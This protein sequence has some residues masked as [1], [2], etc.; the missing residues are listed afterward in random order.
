MSDAVGPDGG[1][2]TLTVF[3]TRVLGLV[4]AAAVVSATLAWLAASA[5]YDSEP[6]VAADVN[7]ELISVPIR[8]GTLAD[9]VEFAGEF[10]PKLEVP[11]PTPAPPEGSISVLTEVAVAPGAVVSEGT[12]IVSISGRPIIVL[13]GSITP[14]RDLKPGDSGADVIQ[15]RESLVRMGLAEPGTNDRY[16]NDLK[17]AIEALYERSGS[18]PEMFVP[19][20]SDELQMQAALASARRAVSTAQASGDQVSYDEALASR[21][22]AQTALDRF[23]GLSGPLIRKGELVYAR[24][25]PLVMGRPVVAVGGR[26][27]DGRPVV[28]LSSRELAGRATVS[29]DQGARLK[30]GQKVQIQWGQDGVA[31]ATLAVRSEPDPDTGSI[32]LWLT[33]P[34]SP[35]NAVAGDQL[36][37]RVTFLEA[38]GPIVPVSALSGNESSRSTHLT[39]V[40][41]GG[42]L[43]RVDVT[44]ELV[45]NGEVVV[46][47]VRGQLTAGAKVVVG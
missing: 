17:R 44:I 37:A 35:P 15:I 31:A 13:V 19:D 14:Y 25:L 12:K 33:L 10:R 2:R 20:G 27:P 16:D 11:V 43:N 22:E 3:R 30:P 1:H 38:T 42:D 5:R 40:E 46:R 4:I 7:A 18:S 32:A 24:Q 21:A 36:T 8:Q 6:S 41:R 45:A 28:S 23:N 9:Q 26:L 29:Q 34:S 39:I 47:P